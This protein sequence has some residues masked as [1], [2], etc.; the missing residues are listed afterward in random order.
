[1]VKDLPTTNP[2]D[3]KQK[4]DASG[5]N[6]A[7][8]SPPKSSVLSSHQNPR[9]LIQITKPDS[10]TTAS[11]GK[12]LLPKPKRSKA[13][14]ETPDIIPMQL[15]DFKT[16]AKPLSEVVKEREYSHDIK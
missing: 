2:D 7:E 12:G 11:P 10:L 8:M 15:A 14:D 1:M 13:I 4:Q 5:M 16:G 9:K 3:N 6:K